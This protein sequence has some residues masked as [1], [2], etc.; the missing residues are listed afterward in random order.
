MVGALFLALA[1]IAV[2]F[3]A[4]HATGA[5][6]GRAAP[7]WVLVYGLVALFVLLAIGLSNYEDDE[8]GSGGLSG[9]AGSRGWA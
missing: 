2:G 1:L 9:P 7:A 4:G 5:R 6:A 8:A 3:G